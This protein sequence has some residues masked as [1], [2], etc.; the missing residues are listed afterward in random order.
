MAKGTVQKVVLICLVADSSF[1]FPLLGPD[2]TGGSLQLWLQ[3][4]AFAL[5]I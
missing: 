5:N 2:S 3:L 1:S 4:K